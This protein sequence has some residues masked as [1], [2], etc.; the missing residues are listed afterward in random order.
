MADVTA[1]TTP[2]ADWS[3]GLGM[4]ACVN[5]AGARCGSARA[6]AGVCLT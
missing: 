4:V 6:G 2:R 3:A 5:V 1:P